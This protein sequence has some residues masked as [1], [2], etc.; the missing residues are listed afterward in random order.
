MRM[1]TGWPLLFLLFLLVRPEPYSGTFIP[2]STACLPT[3][4]KD[5]TVSAQNSMHFYRKSVR[6]IPEISLHR[7]TL[8]LN[9]VNN[10]SEL[11][12]R[13]TSLLFLK[14]AKIQ[15]FAF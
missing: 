5:P 3:R 9:D 8:I 2:K 15:H 11:I 6:H 14:T 12:V 10:L 1:R 4:M 13:K 7:R